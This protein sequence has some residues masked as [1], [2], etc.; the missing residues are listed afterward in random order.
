MA[1]A[2]MWDLALGRPQ[3]PQIAVRP[4]ASA[5]RPTL[6]RARR[7]VYCPRLDGRADPGE[8]VWSWVPFEDD[9]TDGLDRPVLIVGRERA[10][11]LALL[12]SSDPDHSGDRHWIEIGSGP[13]DYRNRSSWA[14]LDRVLDVP[15]D[16]IRREGAILPRR[17]FDRV[18]HRLCAEYHWY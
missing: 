1:R 13:W 11:L 8:I 16:G 7:V 18:A 2:P 9:P 5:P 6:R 12:L 15:E 17:T 4:V 14:R 3:L 10:T